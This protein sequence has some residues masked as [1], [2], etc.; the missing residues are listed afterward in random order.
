MNHV[1]HVNLKEQQSP[2]RFTLPPVHL[3][4]GTSEQNQR[5]YYYYFL[6]LRKEF[7]LRATDL[8]GLTTEEWRS[9]LGNTYWKSMWPRPNPQDTGSSNFD[10]LRFWIHGGPFFF[11][12]KMNALLLFRRDLTSALQCGCEVQMDLADNDKVRQT[13]L[14]HLNM[15]QVIAEVKEMDR[16]QFTLDYELRVQNQ[17]SAI[18]NMMDM[19]GPIRDGGVISDFFANKKA[20]RAWLQAAC[21]VIMDWE[22]FDKWDWKGF[23][24]VKNMGINKLS[25]YDF[26]KLAVRVLIFFIRTFVT[27]LGYFPSPMLCPPILAGH[28]CEMHKKKFGTGLF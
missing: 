14:Y 1:S 23:T 12:N 10:P 6:V 9:I 27:R 20:W 19:W 25:F 11:G 18:S 8:P 3:F 22:G 17:C 24:D 7:L 21:Q 28:C 26:R 13:V 2:Q 15:E 16:L 5:T 4:W